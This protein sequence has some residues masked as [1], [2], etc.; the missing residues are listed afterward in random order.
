MLRVAAST[1]TSPTQF[2][3][4]TKDGRTITYNNC[5]IEVEQVKEYYGEGESY[6]D[7]HIRIKQNYWN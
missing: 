1:G 5:L 3:I 7:V 6:I 2:Q 4:I